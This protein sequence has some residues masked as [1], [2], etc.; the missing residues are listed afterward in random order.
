MEHLAFPIE[1]LL[2]KVEFNIQAIEEYKEDN[3]P[4]NY[5]EE[6]PDNGTLTQSPARI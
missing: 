4:C 2:Q 6:A 1:S 5:W 3:V